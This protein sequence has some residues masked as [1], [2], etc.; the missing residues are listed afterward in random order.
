[1][2]YSFL[3]RRKNCNSFSLHNSHFKTRET[4]QPKSIKTPSC[5]WRWHGIHQY[6]CGLVGLCSTSYL[7]YLCEVPLATLKKHESSMTAG[8]RQ[9]CERAEAQIKVVLLQ[10]KQRRAP[11]L[12]ASHLF[13]CTSREFS[14]LYVISSSESW[15]SFRINLYFNCKQST[16]LWTINGKNL[17]LSEIL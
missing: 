16:R 11:C 1:M 12:F 15:R 4:H 6:G 2:V 10:R 8:Q 7:C 5:T 17:K 13:Q 14:W 9:T 3:V